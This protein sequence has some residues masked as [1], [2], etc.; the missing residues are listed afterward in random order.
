MIPHSAIWSSSRG[1]SLSPFQ[2][3]GRDLPLY[4]GRLGFWSEDM[5]CSFSDL[6]PWPPSRYGKGECTAHVWCKAPLSAS[7]MRYPQVY[8]SLWEKGV[9]FFCSLC[10]TFG[11]RECIFFFRSTR[12]STGLVIP[13]LRL[14]E[15][16]AYPWCLDHPAECSPR[17]SL[18]CAV[19]GSSYVLVSPEQRLLSGGC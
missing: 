4:D 17:C 8:N 5:N 6:T 18:W 15:E 14:E 7:A 1:E 11:S 13:L 19:A 9:G 10:L 16:D 12:R 3:Q 2:G